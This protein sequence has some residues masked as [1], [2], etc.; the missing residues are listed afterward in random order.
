[1]SNAPQGD[2]G[3]AMLY[4]AFDNTVNSSRYPYYSYMKGY[5][6]AMGWTPKST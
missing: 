6:T 1:M 3:T 4:Y 2:L 5:W